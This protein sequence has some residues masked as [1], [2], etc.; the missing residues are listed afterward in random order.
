MCTRFLKKCFFDRLEL[1]ENVISEKAIS[2]HI[3]SRFVVPDQK[4]R[5][6]ISFFNSIRSGFSTVFMLYFES[7]VVSGSV[8]DGICCF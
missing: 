5:F 7:F 4:S 6:L 8:G 2:D 1:S 3:R